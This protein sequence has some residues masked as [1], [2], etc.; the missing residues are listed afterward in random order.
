MGHFS[1]PAARLDPRA[2]RSIL[3]Q[4]EYYIYEGLPFTITWTGNRGAVTV[5]LMNGPEA[6]LQPVLVVVSGYQGQDYTWTPPPTLPADSYELQISDAGSDDYSPRFT[7]P[8]PPQASTTSSSGIDN[9]ESIP[10]ATTT[11]PSSTTPSPP[12]TGAAPL[13]TGAIAAIA[14][15]GSLLLIALLALLGYCIAYRRR[16]HKQQ[17]S[18]DATAAASYELPL[19]AVGTYYDTS[20]LGTVAASTRKIGGGDGRVELPGAGWGGVG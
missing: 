8:A 13:S 2:R 7:Y 3:Y 17:E 11:P 18:D 5:T 14:T 10:T 9:S 16:K 4:H 19:S 15:L 1:G 6:N 12:N 20:S